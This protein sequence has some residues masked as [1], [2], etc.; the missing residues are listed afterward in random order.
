MERCPHHLKK[1]RRSTVQRYSVTPAPRSIPV[2][3]SDRSLTEEGELGHLLA[4]LV[5]T[6]DV[7]GLADL[8]GLARAL[9]IGGV[10]LAQ[11]GDHSV[12]GLDHAR[13]VPLVQPLVL[14]PTG[15]LL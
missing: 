3:Q 11:G 5:A 7:V 8:G 14:C 15:P 2:V 13:P 10:L 6:G 9:L 12:G 1:P 4:Q